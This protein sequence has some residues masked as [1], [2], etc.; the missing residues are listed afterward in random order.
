MKHA[1]VHKLAIGDQVKAY[2]PKPSDHTENE[3]NQDQI[4]GRVGAQIVQIFQPAALFRLR[5]GTKPCG[6]GTAFGIR[7]Q[8]DQLQDSVQPFFPDSVFLPV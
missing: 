8:P 6:V 3:K 1:A 2:L 7:F 4:P 5:K